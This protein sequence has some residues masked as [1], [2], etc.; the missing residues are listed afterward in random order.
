MAENKQL[1]RYSK[2]TSRINKNGANLLELYQTVSLLMINGRLG[3]DK[4]IGEF[5]QV[6]TTGCSTVDYMLCSPDL[7]SQITYLNIEKRYLNQT[8]AT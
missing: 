6:G 4:G 2:D 3:S 7:F 5:T 8:I 1:E